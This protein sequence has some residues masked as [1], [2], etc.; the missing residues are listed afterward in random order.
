MM[1]TV[2]ILG[3]YQYDKTIFDGFKIPE[4]V[5]RDMLIS[6]L[7]TE[8]AEFEV[9]YPNAVFMKM[10]IGVWSGKELPIWE[11]LLKTTQYEYNPIYNFDRT[12]EYTDEKESKTVS[13]GTLEN[14]GTDTENRYGAA[15]NST[16]PVFT[17]KIE[18]TAGSGNSSTGNIDNSETLKHKARLYGNIGVTTTQQMIVAEREVVKFNIMDYI[19][20]SF[21][22]RFCL[23]IY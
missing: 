16:D 17:N 19:I 6:N 2:S 20:D 14:H 21:K 11:K 18:Q 13:E 12:E 23:L 4:K 10:I 9:L 22:K 3:L 8:L 1:A 7:L 5:D 15:F